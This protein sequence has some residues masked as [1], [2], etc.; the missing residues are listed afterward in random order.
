MFWE[1]MN[2]LDNKPSQNSISID[3][4]VDDSFIVNLFNGKYFNVLGTPP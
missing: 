1:D 4:H 2:K 3:G